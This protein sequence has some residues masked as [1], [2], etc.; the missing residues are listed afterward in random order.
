[1]YMGPPITRV[2]AEMLPTIGQARL[3]QMI[4]MVHFV[5]VR[6]LSGVRRHLGL[7]RC[8]RDSPGHVDSRARLEDGR[9]ESAGLRAAPPRSR[10][11][12]V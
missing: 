11:K 6:V 8:S 12:N 5:M 9:S 2:S 10:S 4:R 1:M 3:D 7:P